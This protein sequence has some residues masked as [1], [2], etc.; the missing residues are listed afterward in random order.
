MSDNPCE[1]LLKEGL[2]AR[3]EISDTGDF[4]YDFKRYFESQKFVE[5]FKS[6]KFSFGFEVMDPTTL[7]TNSLSLGASNEQIHR[8]QEWVRERESIE[9]KSSF[10]KSFVD[11]HPDEGLAQKYVDCLRTVMEKFGFVA[12]MTRD[13]NVVSIRIYYNKLDT[14]DSDPVVEN[15]DITNC[16]IIS[17]SF[18]KGDRINVTNSVVLK[19]S[20]ETKP[21]VFSLDTDKGPLPV[22]IASEKKKKS[23]EFPLGTIITSF[24]TWKEFEKVTENNKETGGDWESGSSGWSPCDGRKVP[25]SLYEKV[26]GET[27]APELRGL[28][29]RGLNTFDSLGEFEGRIS[30]V[31]AEHKDPEARTRGSFQ[32]DTFKSHFHVYRTNEMASEKSN[33]GSGDDPARKSFKDQ[34]SVASGGAETRPKNAA[35]FYYIRIN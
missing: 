32:I 20:D 8:F 30:N 28:F 7:V 25:N 35:V 31:L 17:R 19:I 10:F 34:P 23:G 22:I 24:L 9:I 13:Q 11:A 21:A 5:D 3:Q 29:L 15:Y 12:M 2:Y 1:L 33:S 18:E 26:T 6:G 14:K 4:S 27:N 16:T